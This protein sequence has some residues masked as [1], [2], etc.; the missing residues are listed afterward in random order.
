MNKQFPEPSTADGVIDEIYSSGEVVKPDG[1]RIRLDSHISLDEGRFLHSLIA[2]DPTVKRTLEVGCAY[3][4]S[5]LWIC[6]ALAGRSGAHHTILDPYEMGYF[7]GVGLAN[8]NRAGFT[9]FTLL[10]ERSE[11][12]MP[13]A[14][15]NNWIIALE[16]FEDNVSKLTNYCYDEKNFQVPI[17]E[18]VERVLSKVAILCLASF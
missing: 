12:V 15:R 10:E 11:L 8:L 13:H 9:N 17:V 5:S 1:T 6:K 4:L 18:A 14:K 3:G 7:N 2:D 16:S